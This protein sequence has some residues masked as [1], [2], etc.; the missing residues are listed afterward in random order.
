MTRWAAVIGSPIAHSLSP[1]L[2][3]T[4]YRLAGLDWEYRQFEVTESS[5]PEFA[6]SLDGDCAGISVTMPCKQVALSFADVS[7][8]L[9]K[10][11]GAANTLV[12]AAGLWGAFNTDV[13]G[14][15]ESVRAPFG[16]TLE[17]FAAQNR[18]ARK[19]AVIIGTRATA[20]SALAAAMTLG[21][22]QVS[23]V[24][25]SFQGAGNVTLAAGRLGVSFTP[26]KWDRTDLV[27]EVLSRAD[28]V[29]STVPA[30]ASAQLVEFAAP[31]PDQILL[32]VTYAAHSELTQ[33]FVDAGALVIDPL[34]MLV[35]QG[36]AQVKLMSGHEVS[37]E[38]VYREVVAA[39]K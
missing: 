28:L 33:T 3:R 7:D 14:I 6:E 12:P 35:Y 39:S 25:R 32:D 23:V 17:E 34:A 31:R 22:D 30:E 16:D 18:A 20:S 27:R 29:L 38:P 8:G 19:Q 10:T 9:A 13:H 36:L 37:F 5:F 24:G 4:A 21:F 2:H 11:V 15:V 26:I 1:V